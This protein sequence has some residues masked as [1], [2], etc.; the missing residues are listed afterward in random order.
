MAKAEIGATHER[1]WPCR[2]A[3][4]KRIPNG[5][6]ERNNEGQLHREKRKRVRYICQ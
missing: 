4:T 1:A 3:K 5:Q 6:T 2:G